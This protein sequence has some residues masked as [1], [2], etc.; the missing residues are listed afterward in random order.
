M[1]EAAHRS[2]GGENYEVNSKSHDLQERLRISLED[3][4]LGTENF[5]DAKI[6]GEGRYW[7]QYKGDIPLANGLTTVVVKR[8]DTACDEGSHQ[9]IV[10]SEALL[11]YEHENIIRLAGYCDEV[12]EKI[13]VYEHAS[14]GTLSEHLK[15]TSLTWLKRLKICIDIATGLR[16]LHIDD[17]FNEEKVI[18]G[19]I[20]SVI[21][22]NIKTGSIL[23]DGKWK[24]IITNLELLKQARAVKKTSQLDEI[25]AYD[26]FGYIDPVY[27]E[28]G[29]MFRESDI[30]SLGVVFMEILCG[31]LAW[32]EGCKD[33]SECLGPLAKRRYEEGGDLD[34][35]V[36]EGIKKQIHKKSLTTF[37]DTATWCLS[38]RRDLRPSA[39]LVIKD[40]K[41]AL[42]YQEDYE[43]WEPKLP[44]D[45]KKILR[46]SE[47][48][49]MKKFKD[50]YDTLCKGFHL[51]DREVYFSL[52]SK[53][54]KTYMV[55]P[56]LFS[57]KNR[58]VLKWRHVP[59][60][61]FQKVAKMLNL[62]D[63]N[64]HVNMRTPFLSSGA[65]YAVH[66]IFKFCDPRMSSKKPSYV[67]L[68]YKMGGEIFHAYFAIWR[69]EDWMKIELCHFLKHKEYTNFEVLLE[70][71]SQNYCGSGAIYV[72]G[73]EFHTIDNVRH[74]EFEKLIDVQKDSPTDRDNRSENDDGGGKLFSLNEEREKK[75]FKLSAVDI[76]YDSSKVK[77]FHLIPSAESRFQDGIELLPQQVFGFKCKID[78]QMLSPDT[79][80]M[81]YLVFKLSEKC[82]GLHCPVRVRNVLQWKN[83][84]IELV[85]FRPPSAWDLLVTNRVPKMRED[86]WMEVMVWKFNSTSELR[87]DG[88]PMH[89]KFITYEG[90][91]SGLIVS[92][93]EIRPM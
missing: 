51:R 83:K 44:R 41:E 8:F 88:I 61:R 32:E 28:Y 30:Y 73:I 54:E 75:H 49:K 3:I 70:G 39:F 85:Y 27:N 42:E 43:T 22:G 1:E 11:K 90:T 82:H 64:I 20:K 93:L 7:K 67:K 56:A 47:I 33:P 79:N 65:N 10:E 69:D 29:I 25:Y 40:L 2:P 6:I 12:N 17:T 53:G 48:P 14:N 71:F 37:I 77:P 45:Y 35:L 92:G 38:D 36:F 76:L 58:R 74:E 62:S 81:C 78:S 57:Y 34:E 24:A 72:E 89:L 31:R 46:F 59:K 68:T 52:G 18:H 15:D 66:L 21:H 13:I 80:Y 50:I 19:N 5:S 26:S 84:E 9:F 87:N 16:F 86:G 55:S 60:S 91:M 23:I 4:K 63:L